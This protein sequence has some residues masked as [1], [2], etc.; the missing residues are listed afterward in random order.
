MINFSI[1]K[2]TDGLNAEQKKAVENP[3]NT[4]TKIV[5]GAGTGKTKIIS[6]RFVKLVFELMEQGVEEAPKHIL[7][8]TFTDKA[9][10]EMKGRIVK[11]L[12]EN[13]IDSD[14]LWVSTFHSFCSRILKKHSIEAG[15]S[16]AFKITTSPILRLSALIT[17]SLPLRLTR[18]VLGDKSISLATASVVF[19]FAFCSKYF[20]T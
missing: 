7:V 17:V 9:A 5:A 18:A 11:E 2:F 14:D 20:P 16:P 15:L 19:S 1:E 3:V 12:E 10:G 8:I 6:K 4:C 13:G